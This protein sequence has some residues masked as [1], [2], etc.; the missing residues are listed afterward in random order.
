[1]ENVTGKEK[2]GERKMIFG[3]QKPFIERQPTKNINEILFY[4][5][6]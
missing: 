1:M 2:K 4:H 6:T 5:I 3:I